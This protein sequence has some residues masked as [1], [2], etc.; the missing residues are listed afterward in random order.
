MTGEKRA[1]VIV[2]I[3]AYKQLAEKLHEWK[4]KNKIQKKHRETPQGK[5]AVASRDIF[6]FL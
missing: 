6:I 2:S 4:V 3:L 1:P 5:R